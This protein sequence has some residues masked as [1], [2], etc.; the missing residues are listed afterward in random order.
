MEAPG[1]PLN[2]YCRSARLCLKKAAFSRKARLF[3]E[4]LQ[5]LRKFESIVS[6]TIPSHPHYFEKKGEKAVLELQVYL[7]DARKRMQELHGDLVPR[8]HSV[9]KFS[10]RTLKTRSPKPLPERTKPCA[11]SRTTPRKTF[12]S[13]SKQNWEAWV[14]KLHEAYSFVGSSSLRKG[15]S[16]S[17]KKKTPS[18]G[19]DFHSVSASSTTGSN[20]SLSIRTNSPV[21]RLDIAIGECTVVTKEV[22]AQDEGTDGND[23]FKTKRSKD[24]A[25]QGGFCSTLAMRGERQQLEVLIKETMEKL[26]SE[27]METSTEGNARVLSDMW[28]ELHLLAAKVEALNKGS[29]AIHENVDQLTQLI[30][31]VRERATDQQDNLKSENLYLKKQ[32]HHVKK[33]GM[34]ARIEREDFRKDCEAEIEEIKLNL[35]KL[36]DDKTEVKSEIECVKRLE[37]SLKLE[38][39]NLR[40]LVETITKEEEQRSEEFHNLKR[41]IAECEKEKECFK[42]EGAQDSMLIIEKVESLSQLYLGGLEEV[43]NNALNVKVNLFDRLDELENR[44]EDY[45][46]KE[47]FPSKS[48]PTTAILNDL[49]S[50]MIVLENKQEALWTIEQDKVKVEKTRTLIEKERDLAV[51]AASE[52]SDAASRAEEV[53]EFFSSKLLNARRVSIKLQES[54]TAERD[55]VLAATSEVRRSSVEFC[56]E[57]DLALTAALDVKSKAQEL[58]KLLELDMMK[59]RDGLAAFNKER[60]AAAAAAS[61]MS[62]LLLKAEEALTEMTT[63]Q[64]KVVQ[65]EGELTGAVGRALKEVHDSCNKELEMS[66][67]GW[68]RAMEDEI[69]KAKKVA[70][71]LDQLKERAL[72]QVLEVRTAD[73]KALMVQN[74][75]K[76][77]SRD[78]EKE[79][80][81]FAGG[82]NQFIDPKDLQQDLVR[83]RKQFEDEKNTTTMDIG[84]LNVQMEQVLARLTA[85]PHPNSREETEGKLCQLQSESENKAREERI[86]DELVNLDRKVKASADEQLLIVTKMSHVGKRIRKLEGMQMNLGHSLEEV[87]TTASGLERSA[88]VWLPKYEAALMLLKE[89]ENR[90]GALESSFSQKD[91]LLQ[92]DVK[93]EKEGTATKEPQEILHEDTEILADNEVKDTVITTSVDGKLLALENRLEHVATATYTNLRILDAKVEHI[94]IGV[95][96]ALEGAAV[97]ESKCGALGEELVKFFRM[98][99]SSRKEF[100]GKVNDG[101]RNIN[102]PNTSP[103]RNYSKLESSAAVKSKVPVAHAACK[104]CK[105]AAAN[106]SGG[107]ED[108]AKFYQHFDDG[109]KSIRKINVRLGHVDGVVSAKRTNQVGE[110]A[111]RGTRSPKLDRNPKDY[112]IHDSKMEGSQERVDQALSMF[113]CSYEASKHAQG[114]VC[115]DGGLYSKAHSFPEKCKDSGTRNDIEGRNSVSQNKV[116]GM[117]SDLEEK[118]PLGLGKNSQKTNI[119]LESGKIHVNVSHRSAVIAG[120]DLIRRKDSGCRNPKR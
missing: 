66:V 1:L 57:R 59:G 96:S 20:K 107:G 103:T 58:Q 14:R 94:S 35:S 2:I 38:R 75:S 47:K 25:Q 51:A 7:V 64:G 93:G 77:L 6:S 4:E 71:E 33:E 61:E 101:F 105:E 100:S 11:K 55:A 109:Q 84:L 112:G 5:H 29:G 89:L 52:A 39:E 18:K 73:S 31:K 13:P 110:I 85:M 88:A 91:S 87:I 98:L 53:L 46:K 40:R 74:E 32:L 86:E 41:V 26:L 65:L 60:V 28:R 9:D 67:L 10:A 3:T 82:G 79:V 19:R 21:C 70:D 49:E 63:M 30:E 81:E 119:R 95:Q 104:Y 50:R 97:A 72:V 17:P 27:K 80:R 115:V 34:E 99:A 12:D 8:A 113:G 37:D 111:N 56:R 102:S 118:V 45:Q 76:S 36:R 22:Q 15:T 23:K 68:E 116:L 48:L 117:R 54:L 90:L 83:F 42:L 120:A 78:I 106:S 24:D 62:S 16:C 43:R 69:F 92:S 44:L 114:D 108:N